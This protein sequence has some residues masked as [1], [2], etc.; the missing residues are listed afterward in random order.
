M[1]KQELIPAGVRFNILRDLEKDRPRFEEWD[2]WVEAKA[3]TYGIP[4]EQLRAAIARHTE[5]LDIQINLQSQSLA[6]KVATAL[7]VTRAKA[8]GKLDELLEA[9]KIKHVIDRNGTVTGQVESPDREVQLRAAIEVLKIHGGY[10]PQQVEIKGGPLDEL[11]NLSDE[12]LHRRVVDARRIV[13]MS[14]AGDGEY[15]ALNGTT[16]VEAGRPEI[17]GSAGGTAADSG[18]TESETGDSEPVLLPDAMR[19]DAG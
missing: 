5:I 14:L 12:E 16:A 3:L 4:A 9:T 11:R 17:A 18:G 7:G 8:I 15:A 1:A 10:A 19:Q 13:E 6:Q 2:E